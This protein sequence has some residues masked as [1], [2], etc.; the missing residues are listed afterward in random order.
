VDKSYDSLENKTCA[1]CLENKPI[2]SFYK[3]PRMADG[4]YSACGACT[5]RLGGEWSKRN[6]EKRNRYQ[7]NW[8]KNHPEKA[9]ARDLRHDLK[10][11]CGLTMEQF[12]QKLEAQNGRCV[13]CG[14]T[15]SSSGNK[16]FCSDHDHKTNKLR[17][18]LC[19]KCNRGLGL[20][21]DSVAVLIRALQYLQSADV[22]NPPTHELRSVGANPTP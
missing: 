12:A 21:G 11:S 20:L 9:R 3:N 2:T 16:R 6:P 19:I 15:K 8:R 14:S 13:I 17:G 7:R 18:L 22:L 5:S 10:R 4:L 1:K